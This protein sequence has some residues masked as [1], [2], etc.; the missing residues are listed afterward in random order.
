MPVEA[1]LAAAARTRLAAGGRRALLRSGLS[2]SCD[3]ARASRRARARDRDR[4]RSR[5][6]A[7][8]RD[9]VGRQGR[10]RSATRGGSGGAGLRRTTIS[11]PSCAGGFKQTILR[12]YFE[13]EGATDEL[14]TLLEEALP[15]FRAAGDDVALY[16]G[17]IALGQVANMR[18]QMDAG[19][20]CM[21][22]GSRARRAGGPR[23]RAVRLARRLS[24]QGHSA[25]SGTPGV[26]RRERATR[27][28]Q[29]LA[30]GIQSRSARKARSFRGG[31]S[32]ARHR[33][34]RTG[35][36]WRRDHARRLARIRLRG[37]AVGR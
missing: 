35:G 17:Y 9:V 27:E 1:D 11:W 24:P 31:A 16:V 22:S 23:D 34:C 10:G 37:R 21:R 2:R 3:P 14:A 30:A 19:E 18:M 12:G 32:D 5:G 13:P 26:A 29:P 20:R 15:V 33:S 6:R 25:L 7:R 4:P 36:P 28:A 8:R